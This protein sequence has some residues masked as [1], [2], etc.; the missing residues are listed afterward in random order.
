MRQKPNRNVSGDQGVGRVFQVLIQEVE[1]R[2]HTDLSD[3]KGT[4]F[5]MEQ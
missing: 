3:S 1:V 4:L 2:A 5:G